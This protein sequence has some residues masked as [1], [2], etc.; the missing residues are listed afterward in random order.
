MG[1]EDVFLQWKQGTE[2]KSLDVP[3]LSV[4]NYDV[5]ITDTEQPSPIEFTAFEKV[6]TKNVKLN[7][8]DILSLP[9]TASRT[10]TVVT[11]GGQTLQ[12]TYYVSLQLNNMESK[13]I[14][15]KWKER[16]ED[17]T[18][19][20]PKMSNVN[21]DVVITDTKQP[22]AIEF[23]AFGKGTAETVRLNNL[24]SLSVTP[25]ES[26]M[27]TVVNI[28][29][30]TTPPVQKTYY[31]SLQLTNMGSDDVTLQWKEGTQDKTLDV[32][33]LSGV[34]YDVIVTHTKQPPAI[35][36]KAFE[37]GTTKVVKLNNQDSLSLA[38]TESKTPTVVT[39]GGET[40][41]TVQKTYYVSLQLSNMG[42]KDVTLQWK[43]G[44]EDKTLD[45]P[46]LSGM[47]YDVTITDTKQPAAIQFKGSEK[48]TSNVV[49]LNNLEV[50]SLTPTETRT[51]VVV[52]IGESGGV[53]PVQPKTYYVALQ[54][55]NKDASDITLKWKQ[56]AEDK[57]LDVPKLSG[58][59]YD[60]MISA[61]ETPAAVVFQGYE[62]GTTKAIKLNGQTTLS[63]TPTETKTPV[64][65]NIGGES[66]P[67]EMTHTNE[68]YIATFR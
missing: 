52:N 23:K 51:P 4:V 58:I 1:S 28:G 43:Q 6:S 53:T 13:D 42:S 36:F 27:P 55:T 39:I 67:G 21:Y 3:R 30:E 32:P 57:Q 17:K 63:L 66:E 48:G 12:K 19:D 62:K 8:Q 33:S 18:V 40:K 34:N 29:G 50:L 59:S 65:V 54:L 45:V 38:L 15:L 44:A 61:T 26:K 16:G 20:V 31:V 41:P 22:T 2:D 25:A 7:G 10:P 14:T 9:P 5:T 37:K 60:V 11:I 46:K 47:A 56:G 49:K 68:Y 24:E 64:I 35:E